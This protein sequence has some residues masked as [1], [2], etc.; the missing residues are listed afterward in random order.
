M[1]KLKLIENE[2]ENDDEPILDIQQRVCFICDVLKSDGSLKPSPN[3]I[4]IATPLIIN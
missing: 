4:L 3:E 2:L 1:L